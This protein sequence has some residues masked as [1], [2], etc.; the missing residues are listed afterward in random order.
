VA[1]RRDHEDLDRRLEAAGRPPAYHL[2]PYVEPFADALA[3]ADLVVSRAG[4]SVFELAAAGLPA[5][6]VPYPHATADHQR[7]NARWMAAGGAAVIVDDAE[8][9]GPR[10]RREVEALLAD[11]AGRAAMSRA[12]LGLARPEAA[13]RIADGVLALAARK[14]SLRRLPGPQ[15]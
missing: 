1:G 2:L 11:G 8:L 13:D 14:G 15:R 12:S 7:G 9:D 3:A 10:L 6:L 4:G 5:L